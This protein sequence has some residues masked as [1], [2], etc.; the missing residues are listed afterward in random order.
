MIE[1]D[2]VSSITN[3]DI[4]RLDDRDADNSHNNLLDDEY[5]R[6]KQRLSQ[7]LVRKY[8]DRLRQHSD[9]FHSVPAFKPFKTITDGWNLADS[10]DNC[11]QG[12]ADHRFIS[13]YFRALP[14]SDGSKKNNLLFLADCGDAIRATRE[15]LLGLFSAM[16]VLGQEKTWN[17][18]SLMDV[19]EK[20]G[21][22]AD[23]LQSWRKTQLALS[24]VGEQCKDYLG[25]LSDEHK[26][27]L[28]NTGNKEEGSKR[29]EVFQKLDSLIQYT[30]EIFSTERVDDPEK[31]KAL[32]VLMG[33]LSQAQ[34]L[35]EGQYHQ[36][37]IAAIKAA[38]N[39][40]KLDFPNSSSMTQEAKFPYG[41]DELI[42][43]YQ[44]KKGREYQVLT[45]LQ[46]YQLSIRTRGGELDPQIVERLSRAPTPLLESNA[47]M[48]WSDNKLFRPRHQGDLN[49][50]I[51]SSEVMNMVNT[52][53]SEIVTDEVDDHKVVLE[54]FLLNAAQVTESSADLL[55]Q[56]DADSIIAH[57][58]LTEDLDCHARNFIETSEG[59]V[60][61]VDSKHIFQDVDHNATAN[62]VS[63][64]EIRF[65]IMADRVRSDPFIRAVVKKSDLDGVMTKIDAFNEVDFKKR[66]VENDVSDT[67][68]DQLIEKIQ[69]YRKVAVTRL[70]QLKSID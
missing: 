67:V 60:L 43:E 17:E 22:V 66:L 18:K 9:S 65:E 70:Q 38:Q 51:A 23:A 32:E 10:A 64:Q 52:P 25:E 16:E 12:C 21:V 33:G 28:I 24:A 2:V 31:T 13:D 68:S 4:K 20:L 61:R 15:Q 39:G 48:V 55:S 47:A 53:H 8:R 54:E 49:R 36:V 41:L 69:E 46:L 42:N 63:T 59:K 62:D 5:D 19:R 27:L 44:G 6:N 50:I 58:L 45:P 37:G 7:S 56:A 26:N 30:N 35:L 14:E 40:R 57:M 34:A 11:V 3:T 1:G 29:L